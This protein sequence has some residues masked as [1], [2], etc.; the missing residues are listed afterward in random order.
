[1]IKPLKLGKNKFL[2][3]NN[4]NNIFHESTANSLGPYTGHIIDNL[5]CRYTI[6]TFPHDHYN[7]NNYP[8]KGEIT[9][10]TN[11]PILVHLWSDEFNGITESFYL[12][13][14]N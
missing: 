5:P 9:I 14:Q 13:P 10:I 6:T 7:E 1:M 2:F 8:W 11:T 4:T 3:P 12:I